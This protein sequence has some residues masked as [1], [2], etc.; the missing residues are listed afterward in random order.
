MQ[1]KWK[2]LSL[3]DVDIEIGLGNESNKMVKFVANRKK[4]L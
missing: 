3:T 2:T 4:Y 1:S